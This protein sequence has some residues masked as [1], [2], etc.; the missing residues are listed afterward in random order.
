MEN[1]LF[2]L[3]AQARWRMGEDGEAIACELVAALRAVII[4]GMG[5]DA[6]IGKEFK[7]LCKITPL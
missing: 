2:H 1:N 4:E 6:N 3:I 5:D 7:R